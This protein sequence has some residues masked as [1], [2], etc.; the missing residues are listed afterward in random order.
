MNETPTR[1]KRRAFALSAIGALVFATAI[2][3]V[4]ASDWLYVPSMIESTHTTVHGP[5][6]GGS[7]K[8]VL[9]SRL[10]ASWIPFL[11]P[12]VAR[13]IDQPEYDRW[14]A[15][16]CL[17]RS[18]FIDSCGD[19]ISESITIEFIDLNAADPPLPPN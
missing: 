11:E 15:S 14:R 4:R 1:A 17:K 19:T 18:G 16:G 7:S 2:V 3:A 13:E 9:R 10:R 8:L 5:N 6:G 12:T